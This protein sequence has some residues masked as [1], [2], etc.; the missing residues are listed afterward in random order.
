MEAKEFIN[1]IIQFGF[2]KKAIDFY[3]AKWNLSSNELLEIRQNSFVVQWY[4]TQVYISTR[5]ITDRLSDGKIASLHHMY[6]SFFMTSDLKH[7][8]NADSKSVILLKMTQHKV[9]YDSVNTSNGPRDIMGHPFIREIGEC[10]ARLC[11]RS[12][13]VE[14]RRLGSDLFGNC[15]NRCINEFKF[16]RIEFKEV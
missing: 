10:F 2:D 16:E 15:L 6:D 14:F 4:A 9:Q 11:A 8:E 5:I 7:I 12:D 13:S 1:R 3:V